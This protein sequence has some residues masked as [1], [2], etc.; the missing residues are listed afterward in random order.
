MLVTFLALVQIWFAGRR[1]FLSNKMNNIEIMNQ[2]VAY[3]VTVMCF[4]LT[5]H[6]PSSKARYMFGWVIISVVC[7]FIAVN[8][9]LQLIDVS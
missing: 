2:S 3:V 8:I 9:I 5:D 4:E 1:P 7:F 6:I